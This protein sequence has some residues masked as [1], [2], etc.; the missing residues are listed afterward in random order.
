L[1][2]APDPARLADQPYWAFHRLGI[3]RSRA[4]RLRALGRSAAWLSGPAATVSAR[5][6]HIRGIGPWT[7]ALVRTAALGDADA[8][9]FGDYHLPGVVSY[10]LTGVAE[11]DDDDLAR[12]LEPFRPHRAR[13]LR[14]ILLGGHGPARRAPGLPV[15]AIEHL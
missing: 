3:E 15:T 10:A 2:L 4:E 11:A 9:P 5:L 6:E 12:L 13:A 14:L 7:A 8:V 1:W